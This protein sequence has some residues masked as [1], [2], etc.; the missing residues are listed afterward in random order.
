[1]GEARRHRRANGNGMSFVEL[2]ATLR[3]LGVETRQIA[4]YDQPPFL[5]LER[6]N[7]TALEY[8]SSRVLQRPRDPAYDQFARSAIRKLASIVEQR[9]AVSTALGACVNVATAMSRM[10]DELGV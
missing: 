4:F 6:A 1:M 2:D 5:A 3:R 10:L 8:Y 9:L 7:P